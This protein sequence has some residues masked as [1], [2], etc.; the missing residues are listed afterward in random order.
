MFSSSGPLVS[1]RGL[2][3]LDDPEG[4]SFA[5]FDFFAEVSLSE[6]LSDSETRQVDGGFGE[7]DQLGSAN[8]SPCFEPNDKRRQRRLAFYFSNPLT[9]PDYHSWENLIE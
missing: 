7:T 1:L 2:V 3:S 5:S 8:R 4:S 6:L 9:F